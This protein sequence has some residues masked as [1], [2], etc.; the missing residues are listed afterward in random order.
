MQAFGDYTVVSHHEFP[1]CSLRVLRLEPG[2]EVAPHYHAHCTQS[3]LALDGSVEVRVGEVRT[4]LAPGQALRVPTGQVH[5]IRPVGGPAT[6]L[7]VSVPP[8]RADDHFPI[9][10]ATGEVVSRE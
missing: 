2:Q 6:V 8:L 10:A 9:G 1:E 5:G 3:Y 4:V 7:S